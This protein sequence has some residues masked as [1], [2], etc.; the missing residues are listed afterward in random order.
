MTWRLAVQEQMVDGSSL[1]EKFEAATAAGFDGLELGGGGGGTFRARLPK[2]RRARSA[3][4]VMPT[5]CVRMDHFI[6]DF[7]PDRRASARA[8]MTELLQVIVEAGGFGA[9]TPAAFDLF[10]S[11]LPPF[12]SPRSKADDRRILLEELQSLGERAAQAGSVLLLEP[13]NR[14]EDHMVN[15]LAQAV[16]LVEELG[17]PSVRVMADI[18]HMNIEEADP[19]RSLAEAMPWV[20]HVQLGDSNRLEPGAGHTDWGALVRVLDDAGYDGWLAMECSLSGPSAQVLPG[21][22]KLLRSAGRSGT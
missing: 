7:D 2:I 6:G 18:F 1:E 16:S 17:Q 21:V 3:G 4:V 12:R 19:A 20:G 14:Y 8:G 13:L 22:A 5:V 11:V 15:T 9:I 10:S